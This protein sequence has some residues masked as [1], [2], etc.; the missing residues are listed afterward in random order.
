LQKLRENDTVYVRDYSNNKLA[1]IDRV[2]TTTG[3]ICLTIY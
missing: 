2:E 3:Q 1:D